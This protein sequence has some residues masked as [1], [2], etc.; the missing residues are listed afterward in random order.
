MAL[1][2]NAN[3]SGY[4][5]AH[6]DNIFVVFDSVKS[7]NSEAYPDYKYVCDV[8]IGATLVTRLKK[9]PQPD[10]SRGVF[11][12]GPIIRAYVSSVFNPTPAVLRA[13]QSGL[14][15]F[16]VTATMKFGDE[17]DL[18]TYTNLLV[19]SAR[20]YYNHYN[21][22]LLGV[23]SNLDEYTDK[24]LTVRPFATPVNE[25][26]AFCFISFLPTDTDNVTLSIKAYN[27]AGVLLGTITQ[28]YAPS[29]ANT[30]QI[31]NVAPSVIGTHT[32]GFLANAAYYTVEFQTPNDTG[33]SLLRFDITCE[34]IYEVK[35]LHFLNRFGGFESKNFSKVSKKSTTIN[36]S[37]FGKLPY[38]ISS[39]GAVEYFNS[40]KVYNEIRSVYASRYQEKLTLNTDILS[41][42]EY[43]WLADLVHSPLVYLEDSGYFI[44]VVISQNNYDFR[45]RQTDKLTNLTLDIE[46]GESFTTQYR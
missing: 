39:V 40:N 44:P 4:P 30:L 19:D 27:S 7:A 9:V 13:Q 6:G 12:V 42:E 3:P 34:A 10:N 31:F 18:T 25:N 23:T 38:T 15:E 16:F 46:F 1:V 35:T 11:N 17:Y 41:D 43:I 45:K 33:D 29:A 21:G 24:A 14:N 20:N 2:L 28:A 26:D 8:Y 37:E 5:S 32:P 22:R 36:K